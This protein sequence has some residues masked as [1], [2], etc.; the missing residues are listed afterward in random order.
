MK[1]LKE[2]LQDPQVYPRIVEDCLKVLDEEVSKKSGL[3]GMA[4]KGTYKVLKGVQNGR[5]LRK[6]VE[7]LLPEFV[8]K[9]EPHYLAYSQGKDPGSW[10][11]F[12][13]PQYETIAHEL[14]EVTD[15]KVARTRE[16]TLRSA[17]EKL[18]PR[19]HREVVGS[20][21]ALARMMERYLPRR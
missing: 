11:A 21:P 19:A 3:T 15:A 8:E 20:L 14:L 1:S 17:Y 18:R 10:E 4:I 6:A 5:I 9:L 12:L 7:T 2:I 16:R 13:R